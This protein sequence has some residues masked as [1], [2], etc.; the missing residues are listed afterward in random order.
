VNILRGSLK[1]A[2]FKARGSVNTRAN[3]L[4]IAIREEV[5]FV[6]DKARKDGS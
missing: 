2:V 1:I 4:E 5:G 6:F 3:T